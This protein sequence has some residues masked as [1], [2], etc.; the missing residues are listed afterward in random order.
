M[1]PRLPSLGVKLAFAVLAAVA[2]VP[3]AV[4]TG[5]L[6]MQHGLPTPG[7]YVWG[8]LHPHPQPGFLGADLGSLLD[9]QIIIDSACWFTVFC[10]GGLMMAWIGRRKGA[11]RIDT[12][13]RK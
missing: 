9:T 5:G 7:I 2:S 4:L 10:L 8:L 6:L 11:N 1:E 12:P 3:L 13:L